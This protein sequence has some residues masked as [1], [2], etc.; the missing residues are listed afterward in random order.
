MFL[1]NPCRKPFNKD[2]NGS[3]FLE[4]SVETKGD[5]FQGAGFLCG[6]PDAFSTIEENLEASRK[7]FTGIRSPITVNTDW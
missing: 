5:S 7:R 6:R 2:W 3:L 1:R 4:V